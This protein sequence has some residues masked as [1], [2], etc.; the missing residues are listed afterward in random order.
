VM[1]PRLL[2]AMMSARRTT[3]PC[4][5]LLAPHA[6]RSEVVG[7]DSHYHLASTPTGEGL[8]TDGGHRRRWWAAFLRWRETYPEG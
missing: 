7:L 5:W 4:S 6:G 3:D 8:S 1:M 2:M